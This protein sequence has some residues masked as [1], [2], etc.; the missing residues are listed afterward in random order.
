[1]TP[2][3]VKR[4][5]LYSWD[6]V[7]P[8]HDVVYTRVS[9]SAAMPRRIFVD[10]P[11]WQRTTGEGFP[12]GHDNGRLRQTHVL[13]RT[14]IALSSGGVGRT[15]Y[16]ERMLVQGQP[17]FPL[18]WPRWR[19]DVNSGKLPDRRLSDAS[20][21]STASASSSDDLPGPTR[22]NSNSSSGSIVPLAGPM[23]RLSM[24]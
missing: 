23:N 16:N 5:A 13:R 14:D 19:L 11:Y 3:T 12:A 22:S 4:T 18:N 1:M 21:R 2:P 17:G 15:F 9:G 8:Q 24:S 10:L 20:T 6:H 7:N